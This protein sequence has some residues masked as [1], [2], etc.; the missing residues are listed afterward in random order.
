MTNFDEAI[1]DS[2]TEDETEYL[3]NNELLAK[4]AVDEE[5]MTEHNQA[6]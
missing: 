3:L 2:L 5:E 6:V 1:L 4:L